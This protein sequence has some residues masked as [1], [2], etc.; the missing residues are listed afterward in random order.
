MEF[1]VI[2]IIA[3]ICGGVLASNKNRSVGGW[4]L[5]CFLLPICVFVLLCLPKIEEQPIKKSVETSE[6]KICPYCAEKIQAAAI[7][8]KHCGRD[9]P[10]PKE[11][12][13]VAPGG[14]L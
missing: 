1:F 6:S 2:L 12:D 10:G 14:R 9:I 8:C 7:V 13:I 11:S 4:C 5:L 3:A